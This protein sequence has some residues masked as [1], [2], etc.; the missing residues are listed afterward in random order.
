[1]SLISH[2]TNDSTATYTYDGTGNRT[3]SGYQTG[4]G[5][6]LLNDGTW[7]YTYDGE[8]ALVK[9]SK[10][11]N[12]ETWTY[13]YDNLNRLVSAKDSAT[14]GGSATTLA[15]YVYDAL[16]NRIEKDWWTSTA[17]TTTQRYGYDGDQIMRSSL[18][19]TSKTQCKPFSMP[20]CW[21]ITRANRLARAAK[22]LMK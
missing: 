20:Q 11:A 3:M 21:R 19:A 14:D 13:S 2:L 6:Q 7:T 16:A 18:K 22:L 5:N 9:K 12:A 17:G 4:T 10:G 8:G 15:T 1:M